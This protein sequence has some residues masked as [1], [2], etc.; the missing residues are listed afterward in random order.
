MDVDSIISRAVSAP[1]VS[2]AKFSSIEA[3]HARP[4]ST[5]WLS[6]WGR[7]P[8]LCVTDLVTDDLGLLLHVYEFL[9]IPREHQYFSVGNYMRANG[10]SDWE[11]LD[12]KVLLTNAHTFLMRTGLEVSVGDAK[13]WFHVNELRCVLLLGLCEDVGG[14]VRDFLVSRE[15]F[16][17]L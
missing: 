16:C 7:F 13:F 11:P 1:T 8:R 14:I 12:L 6:K 17:V 9:R 3:P 4:R 2:M 5:E 15:T 10:R